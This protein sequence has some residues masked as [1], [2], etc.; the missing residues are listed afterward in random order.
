M[1]GNPPKTT[2]LKTSTFGSILNN[3]PKLWGAENFCGWEFALGIAMK[4]IGC[5]DA[6]AGVMKKPSDLTDLADWEAHV[7]NG[8]TV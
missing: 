8:L 3:V 6:T 2:T 5:Y 7:A 1:S 4:H